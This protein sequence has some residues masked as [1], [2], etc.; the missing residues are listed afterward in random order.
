MTLLR[1]DNLQYID[2]PAV[3]LHLAAGESISISGPSGVGKSLLLRA[4][5]DLDPHS[6]YIFL[7]NFESSSMPSFEWRQNVGLL[8][9]E[10]Q[11]WEDIVVD[12]FPQNVLKD[13]TVS[14][15]TDR[16]RLKKSIFSSQVSRLSS[17]ERQ[18]LAL[19]RLLINSPRVLLLDEPTASLDALNTEQVEKIIAEYLDD[20]NASAIWV[21]HNAEQ[22]Q[23]V[24]SRHFC[25]E[26]KVLLPCDTS[27]VE[28]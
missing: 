5:A 7:D 6:G 20:R 8:P 22:A 4:I 2:F 19:I 10:S 18:R 24:A 25:F 21:S 12:H 13:P 3:N 23:R 9:S 14:T 17:G 27:M 28:K 11:W 15:W 16:L 26:E 1:I